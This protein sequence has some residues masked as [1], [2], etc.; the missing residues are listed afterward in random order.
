MPHLPKSTLVPW[1]PLSVAELL[2]SLE[3]GHDHSL[4]DNS[5]LLELK[6]KA[7]EESFLHSFTFPDFEA[8]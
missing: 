3:R 1:R 2:V 7:L 4:R 6:C 5:V 8:E